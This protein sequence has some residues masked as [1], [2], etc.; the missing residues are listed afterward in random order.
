MG[1]RNFFDYRATGMS[2]WSLANSLWRL[3]AR[4]SSGGRTATAR[5][6]R[7]R[8]RRVFLEP[9]EDRSLLAT[10]VVN[11]TNDGGTGSLRQAI[12]DANATANIGGPDLITF[13]INGP[14][15]QTISPGSVLPPITDPVTIDGYTQ[16][17]A[18]P[19]TQASGSNAVLLIQLSGAQV[20]TPFP[21]GLAITAGNSTVQ[22]LI[23]NH[24]TQ[25]GDGIFLG[26]NGGNTI[27]GNWIGTDATGNTAAG[28]FN[29]VEANNGSSNNTIGG[30]TPQ[31]RNI[32]SGNQSTGVVFF[33]SNNN[34]V[35]GNYIGTN[36][37]G[38]GDVG[39]NGTGVVASVNSTGNQI[40][41]TTATARNI[42]SGNDFAGVS[43]GENNTLQG[44]YIG[45]DVTGMLAVPNG[46]GVIIDQVFSPSNN[47]IGGTATGAG[48][49][50]SGNTNDGINLG[51]GESN[52]TVQGNLI[53]T[54][55][56]G[57]KPLPN[58]RNGV[59]ISGS[60][61]LNDLIGGTVAGAANTIAFNGTPGQGG[62]GVFVNFLNTGHAI[63]G[64]SIFQN[65]G[66]GIDLSPNGNPGVTPNDQDDPDTGGNNV[67]NFPEMSSAVLNAGTVAVQYAV[68]STTAN[69]AYPLRI[70]F[71][72]ADQDVQEGQT[73]L[74]FDTYDAASAGSTK[75]FTFI[76]PAGVT[77]ATSDAIVAAATD[78]NSNTSEFSAKATLQL[79]ALHT[80]SVTN[81]LTY[82]NT[83][84][85]S[86]LVITP[87]AADAGTVKF[88]QITNITSGTLFQNDGV[89]PINDGDFITVPDGGAG[90]KFT[91]NANFVGTGHFTVQSATT[92]TSAGL[93]GGTVTADIV[94]I[95][96][97]I[98]VSAT[99]GIVGE[100]SGSNLVFT[101][102]RTDDPSQPLTVAFGVS[103]S[104]TFSSDY[105]IAVGG[106][107]ANIVS[108]SGTVTFAPGA[109]TA[110]VNLA[111]QSDN[112]IEGDET[113]TFGVTPDPKYT[114]GN[115]TTATGIIQDADA[116]TV[117]FTMAS[118]LI[119]E[120]GGAFAVMVV[121][122]ASAGTT[123][124]NAAS[125][126]VTAMN[127]TAS[128][129]DYNAAAFPQTITF[130]A[131]S[132]NGATQS[133]PFTPQSDTLVEGDETVTLALNVA[134]GAAGVGAPGTFVA[135]IED[136]DTASVQ[137]QVASSIAGEDAGAHGVVAVLTT[138]AG[139]TLQDS[140]TFSVT[141]TNGTASNADYDSAAF[142]KSITF[143]AGSG[144]GD[145]QTVNISPTPDN[146]VEG[147]ETVSLTLAMI[148]GAATVGAQS[149]HQVTIQDADSAS[150]TFQL[151]TST[152]GE[153]A[154][155]H[156]VIA[157]LTT[158]PGNTLANAATF[159]VGA[160]N[161]TTGNSDYDSIA[162]PETITF[163]AG[164]GNGDQQTVNITPAPD[165]L[166]EGDETVTLA[167]AVGS[168]VAT[169]GAQSTHQVTIQDAD[170]A[171]V[172]FQLAT[173][174]AGEDAGAHGVIAVLT[175][176]AGNT[177]ASSATFSVG[178]TNG[179]AGNSDY[180]NSTFPKTI[181]FAAGSGNGAQQTVN[182]TPTPDNLV[183]GDETVTLTLAVST[184]M[185]IV[186]AQPTH[187]VTIQ[188]ADSAS[189]SFQLATSSAGEDA[190]AHDVFAVLTM[191]SG[192]TLANAATFSVTA[193]NG[194][195]SNGDYDS[196]TF[197]KTITFAAGSGS[198]DQQTV[199]ITPTPDNLVEGDETVTLG[200]APTGG[201]AT[202]GA[203]STHQV[204]IQDA[205]SA[206]VAFQSASSTA[207]EDAGAHGII[208]VLTTASG[209]TLASSAT[210]SVTATNGIAS[211]GDYDSG[212]FP[213]TI[214][215][216]AGSGN[217]V[218]QA[219]NITPTPDNLVEGD[220]D[221]TLTLTATSSAAAVGAPA[222]HV[223]TIQD[224]DSAN[225]VIVSGQSVGEDAGAQ[226]INV[227]ITMAANLHLE[228]LLSVDVSAEPAAGTEV[229]DA[230]FGII[231]NVTF[232]PTDAPGTT[233]S[234][235]FTPS[236][237]TLVEGNE[238]AA[239]TPIG[240]TLSGQVSYVAAN[241]TILDA[242]TATVEFTAASQSIDEES[243]VPL[244]VT[245]QLIAGGN[246]LENEAQFNV[247]IESLGTTTAA[248]FNAASFP[249]LMIFAA[250]SGDGA[251]QSVTLDPTSDNFSEG[252]ESLTLGLAKVS[253]AS[254]ITVTSAGN[255]TETVV[256]IDDDIDLKI[257]NVDSV[258]PVVPGSG[259]GNLTY[260]VTA[261]NVGLTTA[262]AITVSEDLTLP[263]GVT[264][265]SI[266]P[267]GTTTYIPPNAAHGKWLIPTLAAGNSE[268]L[269][270]VLTVGAGTAPGT[271]VI[272]SAA[273]VAASN[274]NRI[275]QAD[276][277]ATQTTSVAANTLDFGDA[278]N[279]Y[280]TLLASNGARH[281]ISPLFLGAGVDA[282]LNG[283]PNSTATGD[284]SAGT[285][286]EDGV[287]LPSFLVRGLEASITVIASAAGKLDAWVDFKR[288]SVFE[289]VD[290][291]FASVAVAAGTNTLK[292]MVPTTAI[293]GTTF[294]RF[295]LSS[296][297]GLGPVGEAAD[298]EVEDY[299]IKMMATAT[300]SAVLIDDPGNPGK[301]V[302]VL[303]GTSKN[304]SFVLQ[305]KSGTLLC[306]HGCK[307][308][309]F[310]LAQIGSIVMLG[311][312]GKDTVTLPM[313]L[314]IPMQLF[315]QWK[316]N[317]T[318]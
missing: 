122:S 116:A 236:S 52:N 7:A 156:G 11:N 258:D 68:P 160:T 221:V 132:G 159:S 290:R 144:N 201:A 277:A 48:N 298:G 245:A 318:K 149:T 237:D 50:I 178:A 13:N 97:T 208:A 139:N 234:V 276:D 183:E 260:T 32:L 46:Q 65:V 71:F 192:N 271:D 190:G 37:Q 51:R 189:V 8:S 315:G 123:L 135:T 294:A 204:T 21:A 285:D 174:I 5:R 94:V 76:P 286:D 89:T 125:F 302:L 273:A 275:N 279:S 82:A 281:H 16:P 300:D 158:A 200:L 272:A 138:A 98:N 81:A 105:V 176:A 185:A 205:D 309:T 299:A 312:G 264:I 49:L 307:L 238:D 177:L 90:L 218:Q 249:K 263:A 215:F 53:G 172:A 193:N 311:N 120:D 292:F 66:L 45:T 282:E 229:T 266:T 12:L 184:G 301:K 243:S 306:K 233:H 231:G 188:D 297:G 175:T 84:S 42:I 217:G 161:G 118:N 305:V 140:S 240:D 119:D 63:E 100:D 34:I 154:G 152:A 40:G 79:V 55:L 168:G 228:R 265:V 195:A 146:L 291:V 227:R 103:G 182:I 293:T 129:A 83:Q 209:N 165:T 235:S 128:N 186:G 38:K 303:S 117:A 316:V 29:G 114:P 2:W 171:S 67:Q 62:A 86:G 104:A 283:Q 93:G 41:G 14:G 194:T 207:G 85:T 60:G 3:C 196:G 87:N 284:D 147:D 212:A 257:T 145:Q 59:L 110:I 232:Q 179:T 6:Q 241:A 77:L 219:V 107:D 153:D 310:S 296:A 253:G 280:G 96:P 9:L 19:N 27:V 239:L 248:D 150:V 56:T 72:K 274:G 22:G 24:F 304:D 78:L 10:F 225:I 251:T 269:T 187:Q 64:N 317:K 23:I 151:A 95:R 124:Q 270:I 211:N 216:A 142:P 267:S 214:I 213:K 254:T 127:G 289:A 112:L 191:A 74:A 106:A 255:S 170:S 1:R 130:A 224:S 181:T 136:A 287:T 126:N 80:P 250:G 143:I 157:V 288:N 141:A 169:V 261:F 44:N 47:L 133:L 54:D 91:P 35:Q 246:T 75:T 164:S 259:I 230:I 17:G 256:I 314:S 162:F 108:N 137:F 69:S 33:A 222:A 198:G 99:T 247:I 30:T 210:F 252:D 220:E 167:L 262:T 166:V 73:F 131:G 223:V 4:R 92:N 202:V 28:N 155:A 148:G 26:T 226:P 206:S 58:G 173:S 203:Q 111:P 102:T 278:P 36:A 113:V 88:F 18:S 43:L 295:R 163:T 31:A 180:D 121:L 242:D 20:P 101:F 199:N 70:E 313:S 308:N 57:I 197:P 25:S 15:V 134:S 39:N 61:G 268:K 115:S 109:S 244:V